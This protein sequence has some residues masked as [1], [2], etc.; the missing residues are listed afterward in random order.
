MGVGG[1]HH[2]QAALTSGKRPGTHCTGDWEG[3]RAGGRVRKIPPPA[4]LDSGTSSP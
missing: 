1:Q 3:P 4:E 2:A